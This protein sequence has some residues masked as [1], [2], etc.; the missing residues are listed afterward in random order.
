MSTPAQRLQQWRQIKHGAMKLTEFAKKVDIPY[1]TLKSAENKGMLSTEILGKLRV[2][3]PDLNIEWLLFGDGPMLRKDLAPTDASG[4][5]R[6]SAPL[7]GAVLPV[8]SQRLAAGQLQRLL[9]MEGME[10]LEGHRPEQRPAHRAPAT[11]GE[12]ISRLM[13]EN[14]QLVD[15]QARL[16]K[17]LEECQQQSQKLITMLVGKSLG[18]QHAP[19]RYAQ[20][21]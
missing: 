15:S 2:A 10:E 8:S 12:L 7:P 21:A 11:E 6:Q 18:N 20:A 14:A 3:Y 13:Q 9:P 4:Y 1:T 17:A 19:A 16:S 5:A